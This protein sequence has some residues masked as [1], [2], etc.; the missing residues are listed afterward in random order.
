MNNVFDVKWFENDSMKYVV[1]L[2]GG[3]CRNLYTLLI[4]AL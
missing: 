2:L 3:A 1:K 4:L